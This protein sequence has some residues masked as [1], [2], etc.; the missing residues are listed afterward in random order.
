MSP[1]TRKK[2]PEGQTLTWDPE[3]EK[4]VCKPLKE[5]QR[6][7]CPQGEELVWN[8]DLEKWECKPT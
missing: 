8:E 4:F 1:K 3:L 2:C 6:A 5:D 7:R